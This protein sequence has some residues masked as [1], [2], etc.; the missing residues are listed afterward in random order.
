MLLPMTIV[1]VD[2]AEPIDDMEGVGDEGGVGY[3]G[4]GNGRF[5]VT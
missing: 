1:Y 3:R 5:K 4:L 2:M